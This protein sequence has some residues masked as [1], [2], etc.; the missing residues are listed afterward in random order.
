MHVQGMA[1]LSAMLKGLPD[2]LAKKHLRAAVGAG[3]ALVRNDAKARAPVS[4]GGKPKGASPS[5]TLKKSIIM[6]SI[7][8]KSRGEQQTFYVVARRGKKLQKVSRR[9]KGGTVTVNLDAYYWRFIEFGTKFIT[10]HPFMRPAFEA[11]KNAAVEAIAARLK[12][13]L[14]QSVQ[15]LKR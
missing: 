2:K 5:G 12:S 10:A 15:E 11:Q 7:P 4:S 13:G 9:R 1:Q 14:E 6:K 3:A 8:E